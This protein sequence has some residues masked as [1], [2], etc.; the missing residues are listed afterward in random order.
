MKFKYVEK[1]LETVYGATLVEYEDG[2]K[3]IADALTIY[4]TRDLY[5]TAS[6]NGLVFSN[7]Q[8]KSVFA[9][10]RYLI[11]NSSEIYKGALRNVNHV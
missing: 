1:T 4:V 3:A 2:V 7:M 11:H 6:V 8:F 9:C 5:L 10:V